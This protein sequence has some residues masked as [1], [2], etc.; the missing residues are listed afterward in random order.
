MIHGC[1]REA[2]D[3]KV[4]ALSLFLFASLY[5]SIY[6]SIRPSICISNHR[7]SSFLAFFHSCSCFLAFFTCCFPWFLAVS[8]SFFLPSFVLSFFLSSIHLPST[9]LRI[10]FSFICPSIRIYLYIYIYHSICI[11]IYLFVY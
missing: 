6:L 10:R 7:P 5:L 11:S 1:Q 9:Y 4:E 8:L 2:M 3:P